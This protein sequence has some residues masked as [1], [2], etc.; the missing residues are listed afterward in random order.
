MFGLLVENGATYF[1][2]ARAYCKSHD[3]TVY[4]EAY[5]PTKTAVP[6]FNFAYPSNYYYAFP[7]RGDKICS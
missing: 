5:M 2:L 7:N 6:N 3:Y 1:H 4:Q